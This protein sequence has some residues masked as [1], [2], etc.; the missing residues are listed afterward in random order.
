VII[1]AMLSLGNLFRDPDRIEPAP[2]QGERTAG[3]FGRG[4][5]R[6]ASAAVLV[7]GLAAVGP[8][9]AGGLRAELAP[10]AA[11]VL[12]PELASEWQ[13]PSRTAAPSWWKPGGSASLAVSGGV[14]ASP[15]GDVELAILS[16]GPL[17]RDQEMVGSISALIDTQRWQILGTHHARGSAAGAEIDVQETELRSHGDYAVLWH[18]Y[19]VGGRRVSADWQAKALEAWITLVRGRSDTMAVVVA[20]RSAGIPEARDA[21]RRFVAESTAQIAQC[22]QG[23]AVRCTAGSPSAVPSPRDEE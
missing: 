15:S 8:I 17:A 19:V 5:K 14:Y 2:A 10:R 16:Y 6:A 21:V 9:L 20:A 23:P 22:L 13:G 4:A 11:G 18:W 3:A 12:L 7:V 1:V